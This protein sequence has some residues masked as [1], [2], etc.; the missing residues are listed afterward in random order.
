MNSIPA[1][2]RST[3]LRYATARQQVL[4]EAQRP[5][6]LE[7]LESLIRLKLTQGCE[8]AKKSPAAKAEPAK[9]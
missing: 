8:P 6:S 9:F 5:L 4:A 7:V 2:L 3:A 1:L